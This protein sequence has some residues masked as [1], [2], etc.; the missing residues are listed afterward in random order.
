MVF[1][2]HPRASPQRQFRVLVLRI[3]KRL[4]VCTPGDCQTGVLHTRCDVPHSPCVYHSRV[5][6]TGFHDRR[7]LLGGELERRA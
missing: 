3:H 4:G 7:R 5:Q 2:F 1:D 6:R